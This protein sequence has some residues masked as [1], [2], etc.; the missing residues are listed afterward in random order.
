MFTAGVIDDPVCLNSPEERSSKSWE[1]QF[2]TTF[3]LLF[4]TVFPLQESS[5][6]DILKVDASRTLVGDNPGFAVLV[7]TVHLKRKMIFSSYI[8]TFPVI[9]LGFLTSLLF[10]L[11]TGSTDKTNLGTH[12]C[13]NSKCEKDDRPQYCFSFP[14]WHFYNLLSRKVLRLFSFVDRHMEAPSCR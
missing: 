10:W 13:L 2:S 12:L 4:E 9:L 5:K 1:S 11:P 7:V 6:W 14:R 8:L 3:A